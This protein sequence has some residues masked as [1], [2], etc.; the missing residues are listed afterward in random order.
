MVGAIRRMN[1]ATEVSLVYVR[2]GPGAAILPSDVSRIHMEFNHS[3]NDGHMG[4]RKFWRENLPR[5]KFW[6]PSI[7][8]IVNR[9]RGTP[10]P[11]T[12]TLYFRKEGGAATVATPTQQT[13][14]S[15]EGASPAPAPVEGER[16]V[17]IDMKQM[18]SGVILKEF[19][20]KTGAVPVAPTPQ[21]EAEVRQMEDLKQRSPVDRARVKKTL[22]QQR[23]ELAF[24]KAATKS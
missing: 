23:A 10:G 11:A 2:V 8:M 3:L 9:R 18:H 5:L 16:T 21:D 1:K 17:T 7:P 14:S 19:L 4:P 12:M 13:P 22:D 6:N 24:M 15:F 20:E